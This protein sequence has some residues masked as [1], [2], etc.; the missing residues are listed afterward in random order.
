MAKSIFLFDISKDFVGT[1]RVTMDKLESP[2]LM[3][4]GT[5]GQVSV[6]CKEN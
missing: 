1:L 3:G 5:C 4:S 6:L 2:Y